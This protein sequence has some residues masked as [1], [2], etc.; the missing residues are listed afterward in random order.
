MYRKDCA[1]H[2]KYNNAADEHSGGPGESLQHLLFKEAVASISGTLLKLG[3]FG[4]HRIT[5]A[6]AEM[7]K[8][9]DHPASLRRADVFLR[10]DGETSLGLKWGGEL[11]LEIKR[12]HA[13]DK[14][15]LDIIRSLRLPMV[16]VSI[17]DT[18]L[19]E[20]DEETTTDEREAAYVS[21]I[22]KML[23][24]PTGFLAGEVL[25][26]PSTLAYMEQQLP[27]LRKQ[28]AE[29]ERARSA[30]EDRVKELSTSVDALTEKVCSLTSEMDKANER[31]ASSE[32]SLVDAQNETGSL[33][34]Q[35]SEQDGELEALRLRQNDWNVDGRW[36]L[37]AIAA[38]WLL[39][40]LIH[41]FWH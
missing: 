39:V 16:E 41:H 6:G 7:E 29:S 25:N 34:S 21:R 11:Y 13:V 23:E 19:Y 32:K 3:K 37:A 36:A 26:N 8:G 20:Y 18:I 5:I 17:P 9:I 33:R 1:P 35:L 10:F 15:K 24:G 40:V 27:L 4:N 14:D 31:A 2:F 30:A 28:L 38:C 12:S 22:K